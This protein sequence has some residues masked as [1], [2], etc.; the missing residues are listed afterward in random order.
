[1]RC[2]YN[3]YMPSWEYVPDGEPHIFDDRVYVFGSHDVPEG[4]RYCMA[5]Y[6][7]W[8]APVDDL[9][10][11]RYEGVI[12]DRYDDPYNTRHL[13]YSAPDVAQGP[14]GRYYL[15]FFYDFNTIDVAVCD[16]PAGHYRFLDRLRLADGSVMDAASGYGQ[17]FDPGVFV[18]DDGR[19]YLYWGYSLNHASKHIPDPD[20]KMG[21]SYMCELEPDMVTCKGTPRPFVPG[22]RDA[23][24]T[25]F[26]GHAFLEASSMRKIGGRYYFIYSSELGHELCWAAT[27]APDEPPVFGGTIVSNGDVG[28]PGHESEDDAVYYLGNTHGSIIQIGEKTYVFYHRHTHGNQNARQACAEEIHIDADGRIRQAEITSCGLNGGPVPA[29]RETPAH[30]CCH[31]RSPEGILHYSSHVQWREPHPYV[32]QEDPSG[33]PTGSLAYVHNLHKGAEVGYK[34]LAFSGEERGVRVRTRCLEASALSIRLDAPAGPEIA[35]VDVAASE[36]WAYTEVPLDAQAEDAHAVYLVCC[37]GGPV[38]FASF[39]FA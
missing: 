34:Y 15:Y 2:I 11:W 23:A 39:S 7:A 28:L 14:D 18:D 24:G 19:I 36:T 10:D 20:S 4:T 9:T 16:E 13:T 6:V 29:A 12:F 21:P 5:D 22:K 32:T 27:D 26:E 17:P 33:S 35:R 30:V 1:M 8:S 3:P 25:S 37:A 31:L 38:D